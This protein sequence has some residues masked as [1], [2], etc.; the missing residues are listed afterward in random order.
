MV[1][2]LPPTICIS[3]RAFSNRLVPYRSSTIMIDK[4]IPMRSSVAPTYENRVLS[5]YEGEILG[6]EFFSVL[7]QNA[8]S[9]Q[10]RVKLRNLAAIERLVAEALL[11]VIARYSLQPNSKVLLAEKGRDETVEYAE[12][13]WI[14]FAVK[15]KKLLGPFVREFENLLVEAPVEDRPYIQLLLDHEIALFAFAQAE[16]EESS[17]GQIHLDN[18]LQRH[19]ALLRN[20]S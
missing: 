15:L 14:E 17:D 18:F 19:Q 9:D 12:L 13:S 6:E 4:G 7:A 16:G 3:E 10:S 5:A 2:F 8:D 11:P 1:D 20:E